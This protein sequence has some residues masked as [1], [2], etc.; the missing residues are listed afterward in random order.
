MRAEE[1]TPAFLRDAEVDLRKARAVPPEVG[2]AEAGCDSQYLPFEVWTL[3]PGAA[4]EGGAEQ[5]G[6]APPAGAGFDVEG[7]RKP[8]SE[9][10]SS[11]PPSK[12][13]HYDDE[14]GMIS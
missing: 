6:A 10:S 3:Q 4:A 8:K 5:G 12:L 14:I 13:F 2:R 9:P 7:P 1:P 11:P